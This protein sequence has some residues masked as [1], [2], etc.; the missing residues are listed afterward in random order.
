VCDTSAKISR[1]TDRH[2]LEQH[3]FLQSIPNTRILTCYHSQVIRNEYNFIQQITL[4]LA[5]R[6]LNSET[7]NER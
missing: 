6:P 4:Y 7:A 1:T 2:V 5:Y 3:I